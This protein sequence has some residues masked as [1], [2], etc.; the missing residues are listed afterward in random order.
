MESIGN[1]TVHIFG[2]EFDL[3][4]LG[5][6]LLTVILVFTFVYW[7]SR[8]MKLKPSGKQNILEWIYDFVQS[9]I[10]PNLGP[11]TD[12]YTLFFFVLFFFIL[13]ANNIGLM[14]KLQVED[15]NLWTSPTANFA[16]D[17][18]LALI[19]A[20]V[21]H[22]EGIRKRGLSNYLKGYLSPIPAMLPM[23]IIEE[24]TS[25]ASLS[26][27]LYGNIYAGEVVMSLILS[28]AHVNAFALPF[29][30]I[31]NILWTTFSI[32]ISCIQAYVF[33]I[34]SSNYIGH[35]VNHEEE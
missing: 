12:N 33:I 4:I 26:L 10:K 1:P 14:S 22:V 27:R 34:L 17:F 20:V 24:F 6:S 8:N 35:K 11:Y 3:T 21:V 19:V 29:A 30:F 16:V 23:N 31:L 25:I 28:L 5:M 7:A 9:T 2:I 15:Y 13:I 32:L 18:A